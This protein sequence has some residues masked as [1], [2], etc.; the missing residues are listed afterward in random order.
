VAPWLWEAVR[1]ITALGSTIVLTAAV[2]AAAGYLFAARR[3]QLALILLASALGATVFNT[4]LKWFIARARPEL[5]DARV[6][7][8]TASF[9]SG[10]ALL[11]VAI[12]LTIGGILAFAARWRQER[13]IIIGAALC[14]GIAIGFSRIL[15][16]VHWPSDVMAG[17]LFGGAWASLTLWVA[18]RTARPGQP[19]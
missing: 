10:H 13:V 17:W 5:E 19:G 15:L 16:G 14:L 3:I 2:A 1:D 18:R 4:G 6:T 7:T 9:P 8:Y 11:S 12:I